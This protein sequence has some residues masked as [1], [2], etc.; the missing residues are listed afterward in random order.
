MLV[1]DCKIINLSHLEF[2]RLELRTIIILL[3]KFLRQQFLLSIT[4]NRMTA[5]RLNTL[6]LS[7]SRLVMLSSGE[8]CGGVDI[9]LYLTLTI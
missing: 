5:T 9:Y 8:F 6:I 3:V 1:A 7:S 4:G 2:D